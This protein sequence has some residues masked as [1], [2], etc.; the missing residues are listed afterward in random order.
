MEMIIIKPIFEQERQFLYKKIDVLLPTDCWR[1]GFKIYLDC[2]CMKPLYVFKVDNKLIKII[3]DNSKLFTDYKQKKLGELIE[4]YDDKLNQQKQKSI[5]K[6]I[7]YI[8]SHENY[9]YVVSHS[10]GKDSTVIYNIWLKALDI[11]KEQYP[12]I[13]NNLQWEI[14]FANTSND[15]A[16][17]YKL[18]KK[19]PQDKLHIL[20]PK[21]G[22]YQWIVKVKN[23]FVPSTMVR[24]CCST[25]KEGQINKYYNKNENITN[26]LGVRKYEST[27]RAS[28]EY[29]MDNDFEVK[30]YGKNNNP[31]VWIKLA[32]IVEWKDEDVWLY[33]LRYQLEYNNQYNV[34]FNR[35]GCLICPYQSDYIDLLIEENY[36]KQWM[37]WTEVL[38]R[39]YEIYDI[40]NHLKWT[41]E[42][43]IN[44]KWK[45]GTS[46]EY[47][48]INLAPT[49]DK[50]KE[51]AKLKGISK[52]MA[53]KYWGKKC[54]CGKK[55]NPTEIAMNYKTFGRY[56]NI[57]N[58]ARQLLCKKCFCEQEGISK[59]E[60]VEL[61]YRYL[62]EGCNLF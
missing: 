10:G 52:T 11:L 32:P 54:N 23:Y 30:L 44:G 1:D 56:E 41:L 47:E 62:E 40:K 51:L 16:D 46:K 14:I 58:D 24:N 38:K 59:K 57:E 22:F 43:W 20:N 53:K 17:T 55:L 6:T 2:T 35:C 49:E 48:L 26:V 45:R 9:N 5:D 7:E 27:K 31:K 4:L 8:L 34:G 15:T 12:E 39:N 42:E 3:K 21:V 37:R 36:S 50:V 25:Y 33:I 61:T 60:Y 28:F 18:I 19:L 29:V 13:Y